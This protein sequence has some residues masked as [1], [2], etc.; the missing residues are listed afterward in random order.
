MVTS[1]NKQ[2]EDFPRNQISTKSRDLTVSPRDVLCFIE[3]YAQVAS[4]LHTITR[5]IRR[6]NGSFILNREIRIVLAPRESILEAINRYYGQV[7]GES[8]DS[9]LQEF[10]DTAIDFT[11]TEDESF[12]EEEAVDENSAPVVRLVKLMIQQIHCSADVF[13]QHPQNRDSINHH[14]EGQG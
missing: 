1:F 3:P 5:L 14:K 11:E 7:E 9:M 8:A 6:S 2:D 12:S 10:T 13:L 4:I